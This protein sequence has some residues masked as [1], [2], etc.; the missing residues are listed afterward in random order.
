MIHQSGGEVFCELLVARFARLVYNELTMIEQFEER[1]PY[2]A[3][4]GD[5]TDTDVQEV[6]EDEIDPAYLHYRNLVDAIDDT[7]TPEQFESRVAELLTDADI[8]LFGERAASLIA[9]AILYPAV[10]A[11]FPAMFDSEG[12]AFVIDDLV[13]Q[14]GLDTVDPDRINV[15]LLIARA[16]GVV[17]VTED[18]RLFVP[19]KVHPKIVTLLEKLP[20]T[21]E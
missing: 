21:E 19:A 7:T 4:S 11:P 13:A 18:G 12:F 15:L 6:Q 2:D 10:F 16:A 20:D 14:A 3:D 5:I 9:Q 1:R 17:D 8:H